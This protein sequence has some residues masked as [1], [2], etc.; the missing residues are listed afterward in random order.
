V[1]AAL[2]VMPAVVMVLFVWSVVEVITAELV[3]PAVVIVLFV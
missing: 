3:M 2:L 1:I